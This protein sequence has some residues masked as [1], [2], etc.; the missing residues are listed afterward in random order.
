[1]LGSI[2]AFASVRV[3]EILAVTLAATVAVVLLFKSV[4]MSESSG[5]IGF[6]NSIV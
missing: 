1:M 2:S 3:T 6:S 4:N 5:D